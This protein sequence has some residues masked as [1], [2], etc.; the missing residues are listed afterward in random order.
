MMTKVF[1][2][3]LTELSTIPLPQQR[4][5]L[6]ADLDAWRGNGHQTDDVCVMAVR[7]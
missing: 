2:E 1:R 5:Q 3:R 7:V 6:I 4:E